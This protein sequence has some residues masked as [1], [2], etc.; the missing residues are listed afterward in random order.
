MGERV[1]LID[2]DLRRPGIH[3]YFNLDNSVGLGSVIAEQADVFS[4][5]R[6][7]DQVPNMSVLSAGPLFPNPSEVLSSETMKELVSTLRGNYDRIII[8]SPPI[9]PVSDPLILSAL[10]D[11]VILVTKGNAT[12]RALAQKACQ[13]L[14]KIRAHIIGIVLNNVKI[15]KGGYGYYYHSYYHPYA[16]VK[17][18]AQ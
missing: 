11:G 10:A 3:A 12:S 8:D 18:D 4:A 17:K 6:R 14:L 9:M 7:L 5:I 13:S 16:E 2:A 15:P 1:L